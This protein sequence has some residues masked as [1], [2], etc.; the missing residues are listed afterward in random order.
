MKVCPI[1]RYGMKP[2]M[3]HYAVTGQVLGKGTDNLEG[4]EMQGMGYFGPGE[5]PRFRSDFFHIPEG[6]GDRHIL[7][8]FKQK[9]EAGEVPEGPEGDRMFEE[10]RNKLEEVI[11]GPEDAM[12]TEWGTQP[13]E[14]KS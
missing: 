13:E 9:I 12:D 11:K 6:Y 3:E 14:A 8:E 10:F 7:E 4:Y 5:L 1:Q 2:V